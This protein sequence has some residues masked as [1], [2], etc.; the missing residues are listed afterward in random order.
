M[1]WAC[2]AQH[3]EHFNPW[4]ISIF[5]P[6]KHPW[7]FKRPSTFLSIVDD[8]E[9]IFWWNFKHFVGKCVIF[10]LELVLC[11]LDDRL[12]G[13]PSAKCA[14][15]STRPR[16]VVIYFFAVAFEKLQTF[17]QNWKISKAKVPNWQE[18][19]F[20][21]KILEKIKMRKIIFAFFRREK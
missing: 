21:I 20:E 11:W 12:T 1:T 15:C 8:S 4:S 9:K 13:N 18:I 5:F 6:V 19:E 17:T 14:Y 3:F 10:T 16:E 7:P 2:R